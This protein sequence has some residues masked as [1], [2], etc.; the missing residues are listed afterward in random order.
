MTP[1]HH[2]IMLV[3][4]VPDVEATCGPCC[5]S[6]HKPG[7]VS[8]FTLHSAV[9]LAVGCI[10]LSRQPEVLTTD[11]PSHNDCIFAGHESSPASAT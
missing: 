9:L 5:H 1:P 3:L 2:E 11:F 10:L 6:A 7:D 8:L 4:S